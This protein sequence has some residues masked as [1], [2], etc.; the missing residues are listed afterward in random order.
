[1]IKWLFLIAFFYLI[2]KIFDPMLGLFRFNQSIKRKKRKDHIHKRLSKMDI[3]DAEF[4]E[5]IK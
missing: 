3:Q 1:M 5:E 4:D 2:Y